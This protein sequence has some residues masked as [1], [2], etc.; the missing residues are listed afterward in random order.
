VLAGLE[1]VDGSTAREAARR[2]H[3]LGPRV[4]I[5]KGGHLGGDRSD[6][7]VFDGTA[8][9]VL[10]A[11]RIDTP[12]THG[13]GCT[14]SAAIAAGLARGQSALEAAR[15]AK[16]F[17]QGALEHA[18]PLGAGHGPVNHLWRRHDA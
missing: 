16:A 2:I 5:V 8:F 1:V 3:A 6:D 9:D 4:V 7:V 15:A 17:L 14:F 18:E 13:T 12:H 10:S 11:R